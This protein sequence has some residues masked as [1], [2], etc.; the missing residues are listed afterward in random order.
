MRLV[1]AGSITLTDYKLLLRCLQHTQ[2]AVALRTNNAVVLS[3]CAIGID[4][5]AIR[6]ANKN[7]IAVERYPPQWDVYGKHA[8][9]VRTATML[10]AADGLLAIWNGYSLGTKYAIDYALAAGRPVEVFDVV[11]GDDSNFTVRRFNF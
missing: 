4:S 6:W 2:F 9:A 5:L 11:P 10:D 1:I 3:G 7:G 8:G